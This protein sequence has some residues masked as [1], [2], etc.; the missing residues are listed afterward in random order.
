M[1]VCVW[2][3]ASDRY[4]APTAFPS[5]STSS[6]PQTAMFLQKY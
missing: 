1:C 2:V 6:A 4:L 3:G 5:F